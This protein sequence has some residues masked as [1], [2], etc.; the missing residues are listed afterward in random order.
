[1]RNFIKLVKKMRQAQNDYFK[2]RTQS[3]LREAKRLEK[4]VDEY[5]NDHTEK[6][7]VEKQKEFRLI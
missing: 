6:E 1:M 2:D 5:I 3:A 7:K 4:M